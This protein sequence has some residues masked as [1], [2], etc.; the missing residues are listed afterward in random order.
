MVL[1]SAVACDRPAPCKFL[2][3]DSCPNRFLCTHKEADL[4]LHLDIGLVLQAG[5]MGLQPM[6]MDVWWSW[7]VSCMIFSRNKLKVMRENKHP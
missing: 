2:S 7:S 5:D 4:A 1:E 6:E 3:L